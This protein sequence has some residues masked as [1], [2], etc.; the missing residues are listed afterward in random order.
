MG[1][2]HKT[3]GIM[4]ATLKKMLQNHLRIIL[5]PCFIIGIN[6]VFHDRGNSAIKATL[7]LYTFCDVV[8]NIL[9]NKTDGANSNA[10]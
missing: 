5:T 10:F 9:F 3:Q 6:R 7:F 2:T 4:R 8:Q 1:N